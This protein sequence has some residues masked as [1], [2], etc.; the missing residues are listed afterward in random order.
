MKKVIVA[1]VIAAA[2]L[3]TVEAQVSRVITQAPP[4]EVIALANPVNPQSRIIA[5]N[6]VRPPTCDATL[7]NWTVWLQP[8]STSA[9]YNALSS[10]GV[11]VTEGRT[12]IIFTNIGHANPVGAINAAKQAF[13]SALNQ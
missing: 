9:V 8:V 3:A 7:T 4:I 11:S 1:A 10:S 5:F 6:V 2:V 12:V 13:R